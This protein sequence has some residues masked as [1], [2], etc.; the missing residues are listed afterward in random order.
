MM[1]KRGFALA[2]A[3]AAFAGG[4][5][6]GLLIGQGRAAGPPPESMV[7]QS[8]SDSDK[9]PSVLQPPA[10]DAEVSRLQLRI[11]ELE[12]ELRVVQQP[13]PKPPSGDSS[14]EFAALVYKDYLEME[15]GGAARNP[16]PDKLREFLGR[17]SRLDQSSAGYFIERFREAAKGEDQVDERTVAI[18]LTLASGGAAAAEFVN[19][20]LH[21][22]TL[23]PAHRMNLLNE[24]SG[25]SGGFFSIRRLPVSEELTSTALV[26]AKSA[27]EQDRKGGAGLLGGVRTE[28]SR[29]ELRRLIEEDP[30]LKVKTAAVLSLGHVGDPSTQTFL[31]NFWRSKAATLSGSEGARLTK[32]IEGALKEL[33]EAPR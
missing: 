33:A 8:H 22:P 29:S 2:A 16:D 24:L 26:L 13:A 1:N 23:H 27:D 7:K 19:L 11:R 25:L 5:A 31:E 20:L 12:S 9:T 6:T 4:I 28:A 32:A 10:S 3:I 21:D 30:N 14:R 18:E 17:L 15:K